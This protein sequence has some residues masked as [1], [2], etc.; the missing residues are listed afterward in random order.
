M[1]LELPFF[2]TFGQKRPFSDLNLPATQSFSRIPDPNL[3]DIEKKPIHWALVTRLIQ[4]RHCLLPS[5][6]ITHTLLP[7]SLEG[8]RGLNYILRRY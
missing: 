3:S 4:V 5:V 6:I 8:G 2:V 1:P 7:L